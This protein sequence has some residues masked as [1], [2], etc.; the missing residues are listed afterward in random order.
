MYPHERSLVRKLANKPFAIVGVNSDRNLDKVRSTAA[1]KSISWRSFW[2]G[3]EG[4]QGPISKKWQITGWPTTYLIDKDGV[5]RHKN[6]RGEALDKAIEELIAEMGEEVKLVGIDHE[7]ED[8]AA[9]EKAKE[10]A[11]AKAE[12]AAKAPEPAAEKADTV[13]PK[14]TTV[15]APA[16]PA[17]RTKPAEKPAEEAKPAQAKPNQAK[18]AAIEPAAPKPTAAQ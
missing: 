11:E 7:A 13:A 12:K 10:Q 16:V 18:P 17:A 15:E 4:T 6:L 1:K 3:E 14:P 2:N 8:Q 9:L 5:I